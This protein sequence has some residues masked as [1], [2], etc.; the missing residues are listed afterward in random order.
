MYKYVSYSH[1]GYMNDLWMA[2]AIKKSAWLQTDKKQT[3]TTVLVAV[4]ANMWI[5]DEVASSTTISEEAK[6]FGRIEQ[7][8]QF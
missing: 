8:N 1:P 2:K 3:A 7:H 5:Y 6:N 4:V